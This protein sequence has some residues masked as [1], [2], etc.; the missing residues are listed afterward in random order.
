MDPH[1]PG[2]RLAGGA[3]A[4]DASRMDKVLERQGY[5]VL[6]WG[7][8]GAV[9]WAAT[10]QQESRHAVGAWGL[11]AS[12]WIAVSWVFAG[13]SQ[14]WVAFFWRFELHRGA[15]SA[16]LGRAGFLIHR[17][18]YVTLFACRLLPLLA[19]SGA[20]AGTLAIPPWLRIGFMAVTLPP[21]LWAIHCAVFYFGLDRASGADHFDPAYRKARFEERGIYR[22]VNNS[23]YA[24]ALLALYYPGVLDQSALALITAAVHHAFVWV[25]Y[26]CTE[27]PDLRE[28]YGAAGTD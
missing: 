16:R 5:H 18:G 13:L 24:V 26:Y 28:I 23:M 2:V 22:Y 14:F 8:L 6:A 20:T 25:H 1:R 19:I 10:L 17:I 15:I 12:E 11:T 7:V 27:K 9:L 4:W 21:T 3:P